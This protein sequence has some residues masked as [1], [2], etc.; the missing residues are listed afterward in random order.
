MMVMMMMVM[1]MTELN[2]HEDEQ[3]MMR[4]V[5]ILM[6]MIKMMI[7]AIMMMTMMIM[8]KQN[9]HQ[10]AQSYEDEHNDDDDIKISQTFTCNKIC[11]VCRLEKDVWISYDDMIMT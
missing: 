4:I 8:T 7:T 1:M 3:N 6:S 2:Y 10:D 11:N 5:M 9:Y